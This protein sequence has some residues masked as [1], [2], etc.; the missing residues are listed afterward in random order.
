[1]KFGYVNMISAAVMRAIWL[2]RNDMI[3]LK[4]DWRCKR[5]DEKDTKDVCRMETLMQG[6][7]GD[8][9]EV[10]FFLGEP[11]QRTAEDQVIVHIL[12]G[13]TP[14]KLMNPGVRIQV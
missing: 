6:E 5:S 9:E 1:V 13:G 8:D 2:I 10:V 12:L 3:F 11:A 7:L 14:D 4:Q